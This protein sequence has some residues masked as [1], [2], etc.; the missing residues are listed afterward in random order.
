MSLLR[1]LYREDYLL[2]KFPQL[3]LFQKEPK[4]VLVDIRNK[5]LNIYGISEEAILELIEKRK[6]AKESKD[7]A[8]ADEIRNQLTSNG[9]LIKD[10]SAGTEWDIDISPKK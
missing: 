9:I 5:Y 1:H 4:S 6:I 7:Y 3:E 2:C 8:T 10:T